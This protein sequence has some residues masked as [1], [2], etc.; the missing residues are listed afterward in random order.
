MR[1]FWLVAGLALAA[2]IG[3]RGREARFGATELVAAEELRIGSPDDPELAFTRFRDLE[4][5]PDG[6][7]YTLHPQERAIRVHDSSGAFLRTIGREGEGPGEFKNLGVMGMLGDTL[8]AL[9]HGTYRFSFFDL[10][11]NLLGSRRIPIE[12]GRTPDERPPR[13]NGLFSDG[14]ISGSLPTWSR[15]VASGE[16]TTDVILRLDSTGAVLDTIASYSLENRDWEVTDP[17]DPGS[18]AA[19]APQPFRDTELVRASYY[20]P[21]VVRV[22]RTAATTEARATF[23]VTALTFAGDTLFARDFS[24]TPMALEQAL[25]DSLVDVLAA[26][27]TRSRL[28]GATPARVAVWARDALYTP[29]YHPPVSEMMIGRDGSVWLRGEEVG[30]PTVNW[31]VLSPEGEPVGIVELPARFRPLLAD[32]DNLWGMELDELDVPYIVRYRV[33]LSSEGT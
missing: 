19:Y 14:S 30:A 23:H 26:S 31:R 25:V 32:H 24:Y 4:V 29:E 7:I 15:L 28:P 20:Q 5:G 22:D 27:L 6:T 13:P 16:I 9:D 3:E 18:W 33:T 1:W 2:C 17:D 12:L 8:W 11:G 10:G 21:L